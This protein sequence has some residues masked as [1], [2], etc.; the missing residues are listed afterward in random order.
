MSAV[1]DRVRDPRAQAEHEAKLATL[2]AVFSRLPER[3]R[4][5]CSHPATGSSLTEAS[6]ALR[7]SG[8]DVLGAA[9]IAATER[10]GGAAPRVAVE[11]AEEV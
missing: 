2:A 5:R 3:R 7:V 9:V 8:I 4:R 6:R 10:T 11:R 1:A